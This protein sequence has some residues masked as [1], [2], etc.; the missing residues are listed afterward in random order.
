MCEISVCVSLTGLKWAGHVIL[1]RV[2]L[3]LQCH[4]GFLT[5]EWALPT[6]HPNEPT[7]YNRTTVVYGIK[8]SFPFFFADF[9]E[10]W[11]KFAMYMDGNPVIL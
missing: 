4:N 5:E 2:H 1:L 7:P 10:L 8:Q 9:L 6:V 3:L 11:L